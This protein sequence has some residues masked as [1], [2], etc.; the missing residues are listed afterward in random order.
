[1]LYYFRGELQNNYQYCVKKFIQ[2]MEEIVV[3]LAEG[4]INDNLLL[5]IIDSIINENEFSESLKLN[6]IETLWMNN[7]DN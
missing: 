7:Y 3:W 1:M 6:I 5:E 4:K 2:E